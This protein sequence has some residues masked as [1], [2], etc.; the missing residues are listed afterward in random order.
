VICLSVKSDHCLDVAIV[1]YVECSCDRCMLALKL[2]SSWLDVP[3]SLCTYA[4][5]VTCVRSLQCHV[6]LLLHELWVWMMHWRAWVAGYMYYRKKESSYCTP[7]MSNSSPMFCC[8]QSDCI[9]MCVTVNCTTSMN[10][11]VECCFIHLCTTMSDVSSNVAQHWCAK[12][13]THH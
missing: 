11:S 9:S 3:C 7:V 5:R 13:C 10:A 4:S 12:L 2:L 1:A 6:I 8:P